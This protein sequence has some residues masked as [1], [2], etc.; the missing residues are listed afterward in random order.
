[1]SLADTFIQCALQ[2]VSREGHCSLSAQLAQAIYALDLSPSNLALALVFLDRY[3]SNAVNCLG[4]GTAPYYTIISALAVA[5]KYLNDQSYTLKTWKS[6]LHKCTKFKVLLTLLNQLETHF[7]AALDYC[8]TSK[9]DSRMWAKFN[10]LDS[11]NVQQLQNLMAP[12]DSCARTTEF[13]PES[14]LATPPLLAMQDG[15]TPAILQ[16]HTPQHATS[17]R[18]CHMPITPMS[19][20]YMPASFLPTPMMSV[21]NPGNKRRRIVICE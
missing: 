4:P 7:L 11:L 2:L 21:W 3:T 19:L 18:H 10:A 5:N 1:M 8:L 20:D 13:L 14:V 12:D 17:M 15:T 9:H 16:V 6:V